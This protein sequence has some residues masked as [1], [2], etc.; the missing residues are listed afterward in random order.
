MEGVGEW[1]TGPSDGRLVGNG[2]IPLHPTP[3]RPP[4]PCSTELYSPVPNSKLLHTQTFLVREGN[5]Y[6]ELVLVQGYKYSGAAVQGTRYEYIYIF[7]FHIWKR[8]PSAKDEVLV[9]Q[10]SVVR[11]IFKEAPGILNHF[12]FE[13]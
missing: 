13:H 5:V 8:S 7:I 4:V 6:E 9:F 12:I 1:A 10:G 3:L 11:E 2:H